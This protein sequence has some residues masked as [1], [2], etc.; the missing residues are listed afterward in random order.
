[1]SNQCS[2]RLATYNI[3]NNDAQ[4]QREKCILEELYKIDA[5]VVGLQE[6]TDTFYERVLAKNEVFP[7]SCFYAYEGESEGLAILSKFPI[8]NGSRSGY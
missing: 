3:W 5:E 7:Y 4:I 6:V 2:L 1:M 8:C